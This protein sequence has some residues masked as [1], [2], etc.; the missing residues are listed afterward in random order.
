VSLIMFKSSFSGS[1]KDNSLK[2]GVAAE[3]TD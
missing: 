2:E 1:Y 3:R